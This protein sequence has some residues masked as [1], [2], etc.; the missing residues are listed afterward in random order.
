MT[1]TEPGERIWGQMIEL[2]EADIREFGRE[3]FVRTQFAL[4]I[5]ALNRQALPVVTYAAYEW[6]QDTVYHDRGSGPWYLKIK[7]YAKPAPY[8]LATG[9]FT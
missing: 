7:V 2:S 4:A 6:K 5:H 9:P 1:T 8:K 3:F